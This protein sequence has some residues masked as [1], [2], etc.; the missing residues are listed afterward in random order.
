MAKTKAYKG[1]GMEGVIATWY[2]R[3]TARDRDDVWRLARR[4]A[5]HLSSG[6]EV[7]EIAPGPGYLAVEIAQLTG[8]RITGVDI[9]RSFVALAR[10]NARK[11]GVRVDFVHGDAADLPFPDSRFEFV[12]CRAAF[13]N[14]TRPL[15]AL[16]EIHRALRP[17]GTA[18]IIDLR[19]D[20]SPR[21]LREYVKDHGFFGGLLTKTIFNTVLKKRAY[22]KQTITE[23]V[24]RSKFRRG[25]VRMDP[26]GFEL[27]LRKEHFPA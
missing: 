2:A 10:D 22:T 21:A 18:L 8:D 26:L 9:S 12:V 13:K 1:I 4:I 7:L 20:F 15:T 27:W 23:L 3:Q 25:E 24:E 6:A 17:A 11:A 19:R 5:A 16:N 14:F